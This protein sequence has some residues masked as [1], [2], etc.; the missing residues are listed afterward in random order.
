VEGASRRGTAAASGHQTLQQQLFQGDMLMKIKFKIGHSLDAGCL[1]HIADWRNKQAIHQ[2]MHGDVL[3]CG[4]M[5]N[6][7]LHGNVYRHKGWA[8]I[9]ICRAI[10]PSSCIPR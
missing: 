10:V 2:A 3:H 1:I 9:A 7:N 6:E 5:Q 8:C 4:N